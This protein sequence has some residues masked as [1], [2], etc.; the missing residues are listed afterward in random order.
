MST[1]HA[2]MHQC[3]SPMLD[4]R[5]VGSRIARPVVFAA[6]LMINLIPM[7][8]TAAAHVK[9]FVACNISDD[10]LPVQAVFTTTCFS[11][12]A[13]FLTLFYL[14]CE[15]EQTAFGA[16]FSRLLDRWTGPLHGRADDLL[17]AV[18][19]ISFALLWA[20]GGLILTPELKANSAWLS[21]IQLLIPCPRSRA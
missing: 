19:A 3:G 7:A 21:A 6:C 2:A 9:W 15:A 14:A 10:P 1:D 13:L 20:D 4:A 11:F 18:A 16:T 5:H 8:T 12:L 17:R